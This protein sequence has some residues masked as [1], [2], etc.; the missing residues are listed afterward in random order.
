MTTTP[1][2]PN[3]EG[4]TQCIVRWMVETPAGWLGAYNKEA[5]EAYATQARADL[6]AAMIE[7]LK[8]ALTQLEAMVG[9][10]EPVAWQSIESMAAQRYRVV[11]SHESMFYRHAVVAGD[12]TQ[13]LY[14]GREVECEN[15]AR[16]FAGA[17][18]DGAYVAQNYA[19][20]VAQQ[21]QARP[22]FQDE[23]TGYLKDGETPF[24]R[25]MRERR[26]LTSLTKLYQRVLEENEQL[27]AQQAQAEVLPD[28][29]RDR[30]VAIS[31]AIADQDDRGAQAM[32][33]EVLAAPQQ[34]EAVPSDVVR[35]A[36]PGYALVPVEVLK[37]ASESLG[38]F[39]SDHGW[40]DLDMQAMDNLDAIL[41]QQKGANHG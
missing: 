21:P 3:K 18:L 12:G 17:F 5:F 9:E 7:Q 37:A 41:A 29:L 28:D 6:E 31:Q 25:F 20:P 14:I 22:D 4:A 35:D 24:E 27:K 30:L 10:Q 1:L 33:G 36:P 23:W 2:P 13:Q 38:S 40:T 39:V 19:A 16:K 32:I 15:M 8:T 26:D 34:A 11:P